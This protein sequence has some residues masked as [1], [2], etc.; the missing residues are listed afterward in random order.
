[1]IIGKFK[2]LFE[3]VEDEELND[4]NTD[5]EDMEDDEMVDD[6]EDGEEEEQDLFD[7]MAN[8]ITTLDQDAIPEEMQDAYNDIV[9]LLSQEDEQDIDGE[10][11]EDETYDSDEVEDEEP[12]EESAITPYT[13]P[14][15]KCGDD[16]ILRRNGV[17]KCLACG[18]IITEACCKKMKE[19]CKSKKV[20]KEVLTK[21]SPPKE[22]IDDFIKSKNPKFEGKTK[23]ER[24]EMA[25]GAYY[26]K[27]R[28]GKKK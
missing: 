11:E 24:I 26:A 27:Q 19:A 21:K 7:K 2:R 9:T 3:A 5:A 22:W 20:V 16:S 4:V 12:A 17:S 1:M 28:G 14:C 10:D 6:E 8:F 13:G 15:P 25:L 18:T 23:K